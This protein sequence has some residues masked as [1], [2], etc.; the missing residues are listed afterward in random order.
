[1][2]TKYI[3]NQGIDY[4]VIKEKLIYNQQLFLDKKRNENILTDFLNQI[5]NTSK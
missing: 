4:N 5:D 1:M 2:V 3:S